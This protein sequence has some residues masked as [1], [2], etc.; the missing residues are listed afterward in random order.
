MNINNSF[1]FS[2]NHIYYS[3]N[4]LMSLE[5]ILNKEYPLQYVFHTKEATMFIKK[6]SYRLV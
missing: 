5:E 3:G 2:K 6:L 1:M 4:M